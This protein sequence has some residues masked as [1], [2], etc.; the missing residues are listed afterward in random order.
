MDD[1]QTRAEAPANELLIQSRY[2]YGA[3][4]TLSHVPGG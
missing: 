1:A 2:R 3:L 4:S